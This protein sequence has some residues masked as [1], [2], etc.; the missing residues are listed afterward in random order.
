[1]N[2]ELIKLE[3]TPSFA[4]VVGRLQATPSRDTLRTLMTSIIVDQPDPLTPTEQAAVLAPFL[5]L[6]AHAKDGL[7]LS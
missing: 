6:L 2:A 3:M 1:M 7:P 5:W 4:S